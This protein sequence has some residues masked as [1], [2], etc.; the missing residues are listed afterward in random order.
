MLAHALLW[1][2][3]VTWF[4]LALI[5]LFWLFDQIAE[6]LIDSAQFKAYVWRYL[7]DRKYANN[8]DKD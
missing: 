7:T 6:W 8:P 3:M 1:T 5:G 4:V 2:G